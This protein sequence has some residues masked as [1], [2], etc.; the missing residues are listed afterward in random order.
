MDSLPKLHLHN[1]PV[2]KT[3]RKNVFIVFAITTATKCHLYMYKI[4]NTHSL[5]DHRVSGTTNG[6]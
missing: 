5:S 2:P 3:T 6:F 4:R 1:M